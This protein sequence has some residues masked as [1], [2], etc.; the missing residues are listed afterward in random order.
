MLDL[1]TKFNIL[2]IIDID[3]PPS[4]ATTDANLGNMEELQE[5][6]EKVTMIKPTLE[7]AIELLGYGSEI[8]PEILWI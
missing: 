1:C 5:C 4:I 7:A 8:N 6:L 2:S 3:V